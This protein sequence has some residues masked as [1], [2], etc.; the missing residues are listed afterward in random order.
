MARTVVLPTM[1]QHGPLFGDA[2]PDAVCALNLFRPNAPEPNAPMFEVV[3]P[4]LIASVM[5][6]NSVF[7]AQQDD[8]SLLPDN[9]IKAINLLSRLRDY[10]R[11][12][13]L[14]SS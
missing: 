2:S 1:D 4:S 12:R 13:L 8:V 10:I 6:G 14:R 3:G 7:V 9:R 11:K 5:D